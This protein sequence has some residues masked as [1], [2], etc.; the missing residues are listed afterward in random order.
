[1]D[2]A[3]RNKIKALAQDKDEAL[4]G[5]RFIDLDQ[6]AQKRKSVVATGFLSQSEQAY[7]QMLHSYVKSRI[8]YYGGFDGAQRCMAMFLPEEWSEPDK[9][10]IAILRVEYTGQLGHRDLLGS[11]LGTGI[12]RDA[13]GDILVGKDCSFVI[14]TEAICSYLLQNLRKVGR[15]PVTVKK[16]AE[17]ELEIPEILYKIEQGTVA[18][19]RLDGVIAEGFHISRDT[20]QEAIR[21]ELVQVNHRIVSSASKLVRQGD[22]ISLRGY[23][24]MILEEIGGESRKGRIWVTFKKFC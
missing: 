24:K 22:T 16:I 9:S 4:L 20:A 1:M 15:L 21:R 10:L 17:S 7:C 12:Q 19:L 5:A 13:V 23:G 11:V 8:F 14:V 6:L 2:E 18:S 3:L